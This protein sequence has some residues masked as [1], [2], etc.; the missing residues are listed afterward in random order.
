MARWVEANLPEGSGVAVEPWQRLDLRA[1]G[2]T[3]TDVADHAWW[4]A[5]GGVRR[6]GHRAI[7]AALRAIGG[8]WGVV[9]RLLDLPPVSW[10][11][12]VV[13]VLV[14]RNR[15]HLRRFGV[16]PAC[17]NGGCDDPASDDAGLVGEA[18]H[19]LADDVALHLAGPTAD[20]QGG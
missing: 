9:G 1:L 12:A 8:R 3:P 17:A 13:Y 5:P 6:R 18:E 14:A 20:R 19:P 4:L 10:L 11:A 7:A 2:L 15:H 16:T